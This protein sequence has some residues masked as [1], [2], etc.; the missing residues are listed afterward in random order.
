V[1][2]VATLSHRAV[3]AGVH[4]TTLTWER[5]KE[6]EAE[7][8]K[9]LRLDRPELTVNVHDLKPTDYNEVTEAALYELQVGDLLHLYN[10]S[11]VYSKAEKNLSIILAWKRVQEAIQAEI[12]RR[13]NEGYVQ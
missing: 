6:L 10:R 9:I 2:A 13:I 1:S 12:E 5:C 7:F 3:D 4:P 11:F 8:A